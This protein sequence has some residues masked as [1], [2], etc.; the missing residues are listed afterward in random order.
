MRL[1]SILLLGFPP[2]ADV[3]YPATC[4]PPARPA[5]RTAATHGS[6]A[7]SLLHDAQGPISTLLRG[8]GQV[9]Q[10]RLA[11]VVPDSRKNGIGGLTKKI[12]Y[13]KPWWSPSTIQLV[14]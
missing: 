12:F 6:A 5:A 1:T 13:W 9:A 2:V 4:R 10:H 8:A 14:L 3:F 7:G 11:E